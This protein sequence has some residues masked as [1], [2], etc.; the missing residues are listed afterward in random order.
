MAA[1]SLNHPLLDPLA[2]IDI[3]VAITNRVFAFVSSESD[4]WDHMARYFNTVHTWLPVISQDRYYR[5]LSSF[6]DGQNP[7]FSVLTLTIILISTVPQTSGSSLYLSIK[8]F[9]AVLDG[10]GI[11]SL[12]LLQA[13]LLVTVFEVGHGYFQAGNIS[14]GA[15]ARAAMVNVLA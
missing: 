15:V 4:L 13:R 7:G 1:P 8:R 6:S 9:I 12:D 2:S 10:M 5:R 14:I 3:S 11:N